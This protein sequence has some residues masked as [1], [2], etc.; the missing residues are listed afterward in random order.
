MPF[1]KENWR[2]GLNLSG[3]PAIHSYTTPDI[4]TVVDTVGYFNAVQSEL[5][6]GDLIYATVNTGGTI[7]YM[8]YPV[9]QITPGAVDVTDGTAI[10]A[11]NTR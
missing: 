10:N 5:R 6:V 7:A 8:L 11:T 9:R 2:S 1:L 3:A 4:A